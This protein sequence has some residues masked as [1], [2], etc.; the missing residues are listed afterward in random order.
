[1]GL[2]AGAFLAN[3]VLIEPLGWPLSGALL[4][5]GG[6]LALGSRTPLRDIVVSLAL[7]F[8]SYYLFNHALGLA[9]PAGV[10]EGLI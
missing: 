2:L 4:F 6:A 9:L 7:G 3:I 1:V 10:L 8:G 5:F